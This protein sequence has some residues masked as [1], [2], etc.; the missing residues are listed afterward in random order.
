LIGL[1]SGLGIDILLSQI[2][3]IMGISVGAEGFFREVIATIGSIPS[4]NL[5]TLALGLGT[6]LI[7]RLLKRYTPRLPSALIAL[8]LMTAIV[9][10]FNLDERGVSV[11]GDVPSGLPVLTV[12]QVSFDDLLR[13]IPGALAIVA[14]TMAEG[15]LVARKYALAYKYKIDPDQES[16]AFGA[17]NVAAGLTGG[18]AVGSSASRSAAMDSMGSRS[19]IPSLV[20]AVTV[21]VVML[22]FTDLLALLPNAVLAGIVADAVLG[23]IGV[24]E[25]RELSKMR[26][27]YNR[28]DLLA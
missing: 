3:K 15:L 9:A 14:V 4:T 20:A 5:Y 25:L 24:G 16:F 18:F 13:L 6:I 2:Q 22:F 10:V 23:L 17:A 11:L 28:H 1:V 12:P 8:L 27:S 19:Q 21:A 7:I 26:R